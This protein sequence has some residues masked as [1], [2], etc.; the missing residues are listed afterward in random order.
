ML[1]V[2]AVLVFLWLLRQW[3]ITS[4]MYIILKIKSRKYLTIISEVTVYCYRH[5]KT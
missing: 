3:N 1:P 5:D 4:Y 2:M